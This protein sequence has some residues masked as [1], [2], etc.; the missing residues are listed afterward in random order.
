[1]KESDFTVK[2]DDSK[3]LSEE[4]REVAYKQIFEKAYI[5]IGIVP[6]DTIDDINIHQASMLAMEKSI[7]SLEVEPDLLLVDGNIRLRSRHQQIAIVRGD[8]KSLSIA[9]ASI[10]AKVTRDRLL[11]YYDYIFP[12]YGF[13]KHKGYGTKAHRVALKENG[14]TPIHRRSFAIRS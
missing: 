2:I 3:K 8:Q 6:E 14:F 9:C 13:K 5:G 10:I 7:I 12:G 1:L 11:K 4:Q